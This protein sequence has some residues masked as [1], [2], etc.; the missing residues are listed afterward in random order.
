M[1]VTIPLRGVGARPRAPGRPLFFVVFRAV[2]FLLCTADVV[3]FTAIAL[4]VSL[5]LLPQAANARE[6]HFELEAGFDLHATHY[7]RAPQLTIGDQGPRQEGPGLPSIGPLT[8]GGAA[9]DVGWALDD[10]MVFP[11]FGFGFDTALG[12]SPR[13]MTSIDGSI[14]EVRPWTAWMYDIGLPGVGVRFKEQRWM[15]EAL[16]RTGVAILQM[17][18][19]VATGAEAQEVTAKAATFYVR[20]QG[21]AC[22]RLDPTQR[23]CV[24]VAPSVYEFGFGNGASVGFRWEIGP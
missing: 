24:F 12:A 1:S 23:V 2:G 17:N 18:G 4:L 20:I 22:R 9:L 6:S 15:F 13:V 7:F 19:S 14:A 8:L 16:V 10:R 5:L 3:R 21:Q 11:V